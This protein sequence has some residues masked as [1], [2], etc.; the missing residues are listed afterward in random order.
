MSNKVLVMLGMIV[1]SSIGGYI[2]ILLGASFLSF[3]SLIG[4]AVGGI[5][6]IYITFQ[7]S[8]S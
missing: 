4:S 6:G 8:K 5:L 1:G 7:L 2:P 3:F